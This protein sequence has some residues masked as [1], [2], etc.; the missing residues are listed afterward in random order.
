M[1]NSPVS[2]PL[3]VDR[4]SL[5]PVH[6]RTR[7]N[8]NSLNSPG[9]RAMG[10]SPVSHPLRVDRP[11]LTPVHPRTRPNPNSPSSPGSR[12]STATPHNPA[13]TLLQGPSPLMASTS[14]PDSRDTAL[15]GTRPSS[16]RVDN[17]PTVSL[18][19]PGSTAN[20]GSTATPHNPDSTVSNPRTRVTTACPRPLSRVAATKY[21]WLCS[22][23]CPASSSPTSGGYRRW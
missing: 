17:S 16:P 6:P 22:P 5:T 2:H 13:T 20:R 12:A 10:N 4:P 9:S 8:P 15:P 11:S 19:S 14:S 3:R 23:T 18:P 21:W 7:P 1:G